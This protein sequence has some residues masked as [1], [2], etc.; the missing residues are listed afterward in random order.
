MAIWE[1]MNPSS[2]TSLTP[3][4][5]DPA[6][7]PYELQASTAVADGT[8]TTADAALYPTWVPDD[9]SVQRFGVVLPD[10]PPVPEPTTLALA[11]F[12]LL[13]L[14]VFLRKRRV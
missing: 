14:G 9:P 8:W 12:G 1:I 11:G 13:G 2:T 10:P 5:S 6:A 7:L 4:P 3:F